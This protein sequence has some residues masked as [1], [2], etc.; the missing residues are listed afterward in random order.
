MTAFLGLSYTVR[1]ETAV[2]N[3]RRFE[4]MIDS[5]Y[6]Q[7]IMRGLEAMHAEGA[8]TVPGQNG[9][10]KRLGS[11]LGAPPISQF[12]GCGF[13]WMGPYWRSSVCRAILPWHVA[14]AKTPGI[15]KL[16][17]LHTCLPQ[18]CYFTPLNGHWLI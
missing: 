9:S 2:R 6:Y 16:I 3:A 4:S 14:P 18:L 15:L 1:M 12:C 13:L 17:T 5:I 8:V 7:T 10:V 11:T